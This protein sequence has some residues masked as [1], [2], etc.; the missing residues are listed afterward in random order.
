MIQAW[1]A[2][3]PDSRVP[4]WFDLSA[5]IAARATTLDSYA[6]ALDSG[7]D[8]LL[9]IDDV[10][11]SGGVIS[12]WLEGGTLDPSPDYIVRCRFTLADGYRDDISRSQT[13]AQL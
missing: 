4:R 6:V 10:T 12:L 13:I 3:D 11:E 5:L 9:V 2:K 8:E 7:P 1:P